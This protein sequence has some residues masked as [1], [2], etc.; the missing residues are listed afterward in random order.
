MSS[1]TTDLIKEDT[2]NIKTDE[3]KVVEDETN[4]NVVVDDLKSDQ[5]SKHVLPLQ[6]QET[7][8]NPVHTDKDSSD[9]AVIDNDT[10]MTEVNS[11]ITKIE[12]QTQVEGEM[13]I[14]M[15]Q[16]KT[17]ETITI[18]ATATAP[19]PASTTN[20]PEVKDTATTVSSS[21]PIK[22]QE[23]VMKQVE[24]PNEVI[25][26]AAPVQLFEKENTSIDQE[27]KLANDT[28]TVPS[29][30]TNSTYVKQVIASPIPH[31]ESSKQSNNTQTTIPTQPAPT[32][33]P[34]PPPNT[35]N[36]PPVQP[37]QASIQPQAQTQPIQ[38]IPNNTN[39]EGGTITTSINHNDVLCGRG[40]G[41]NK[42]I[43][44]IKFRQL[45]QANQLNYI[46]AKVVDKV[47]IA[48]SIVDAVHKMNG[49]FLKKVTGTSP[50]RTDNE[51]MEI[52]KQQAREKTS[53]ALRE[54]PDRKNLQKNNNGHITNALSTQENTPNCNNVNTAINVTVPSNVTELMQSFPITNEM[55]P[56]QVQPQQ[57]TQVQQ[58]DPQKSTQD[59]S[60]AQQVPT[61]VS[62]VVTNLTSAV[63]AMSQVAVK[64][65]NAMQAANVAH[66]PSFMQQQQHGTANS[67]NSNNTNTLTPIAPA[68]VPTLQQTQQHQTKIPALSKP[69]RSTSRSM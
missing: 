59:A 8:L 37:A 53:Q 27:V 11:Q 35:T 46:N 66:G 2:T 30:P 20:E 33:I 29:E 16:V 67:N 54:K 1:G 63:Q 26:T 49:R 9:N 61:N 52:S 42:H 68:P 14:E 58:I 48:G 36:L 23:H 39:E 15:I 24:Q 25:Q 60:N 62:E 50:L 19:A 38:P 31:V 10:M 12:T 45:V 40:A 18:T 41:T 47:F 17:D 28:A 4:A 3:G 7:I 5:V 43:G 22:K 21:I 44:N 51:W 65:E 34:L 64:L 32:N 57:Q 13:D 55:P 6:Q 56:L 69:E